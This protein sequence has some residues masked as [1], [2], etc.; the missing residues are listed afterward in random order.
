M[1]SIIIEKRIV[2]PDDQI[3]S[4]ERNR[5]RLSPKSLYEQPESKEAGASIPE[6]LRLRQ[7]RWALST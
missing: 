1:Q 3:Y 6:F 5:A 7:N 4:N 2:E